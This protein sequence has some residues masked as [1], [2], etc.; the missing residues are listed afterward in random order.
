MTDKQ[1]R[2]KH[3]LAPSEKGSEFEP[4]VCVLRSIELSN[5][6]RKV[7]SYGARLEGHADFSLA[8]TAVRLEP[9]A[10]ANFPVTCKPSIALPQVRGGAQRALQQL[11]TWQRSSLIQYRGA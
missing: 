1:T 7:L 3:A 8:T 6:S 11:S 2:V 4:L 9:K 5:P 10:T